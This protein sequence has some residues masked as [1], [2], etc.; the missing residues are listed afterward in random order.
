M[1]P[2]IGSWAGD[3]VSIVGDYDDSNIYFNESYKDISK[4]VVELMRLDSMINDSF[5]AYEEAEAKWQ[6]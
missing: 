4:E 6:N 3:R 5:K 2:L 1:F